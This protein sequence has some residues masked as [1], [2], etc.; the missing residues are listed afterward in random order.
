MA[1]NKTP[2]QMAEEIIRRDRLAELK[3]AEQ[4]VEKAT[5]D[6]PNVDTR[7]STDGP[8]TSYELAVHRL[9]VARWVNS[10]PVDPDELIELI[11]QT[12]QPVTRLRLTEIVRDVRRAMSSA[13]ILEEIDAGGSSLK[14]DADGLSRPSAYIRLRG[15]RVPDAVRELVGDRLVGSPQDVGQ[16]WKFLR[17][18]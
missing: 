2:S 3:K 10:L 14:K 1:E 5:K 8:P 15:D 12:E 4:A 13:S 11:H 16:A 17:R 18:V 9:G 7:T 6:F